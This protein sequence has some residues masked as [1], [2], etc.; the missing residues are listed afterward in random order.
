MKKS[1][2]PKLWRYFGTDR[3]QL[4]QFRNLSQS[5]NH[6][7]HKEQKIINLPDWDDQLPYTRVQHLNWQESTSWSETCKLELMR[8]ESMRLCRQSDQIRASSLLDVWMAPACKDC[9][10]D[11]LYCECTQVYP[12]SSI[13]SLTRLMNESHLTNCPEIV[14]IIPNPRI[15]C[16]PTWVNNECTIYRQH[17]KW[18]CGGLAQLIDS[19]HL[20]S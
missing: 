17:T 5:Q 18:P 9:C 15:T 1:E 11:F 19:T 10:K 12:S 6:A 14:Y 20:I 2:P 4:L 8:G 13:L 3:C 7:I 16:A